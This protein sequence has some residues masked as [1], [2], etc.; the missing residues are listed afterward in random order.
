MSFHF[1]FEGSDTRD[2]LTE[3][4]E[5]EQL[6]QFRVRDF[7]SM[8][9]E[10][11]EVF[12]H[13]DPELRHFP[14]VSRVSKDLGCLYAVPPRRHF[15]AL[16]DAEAYKIEA[17]Y[18]SAQF[19]S[20]MSTVARK[21][22]VQQSQGVAVDVLNPRR[23]RLMSFSPYEV[24][25]ES[26]DPLETDIRYVSRVTLRVPLKVT[27]EGYTR[28]VFFGRRIYTQTEAYTEV[29]K[30]GGEVERVPVYGNSIEHGFGRIPLVLV[31]L[32]EA[33]KGWFLPRVP[34][35]LLAMQIGLNLAL[36]DTLYIASYQCFASQALIGPGA[37]QAIKQAKVS[38]PNRIAAYDSDEGLQHVVINPN[39][40]LDKYLAVIDKSLRIWSAN[41]YVSPES[42]LN[43]TG[44]TGDAKAQ[45]RLDQEE[46]R[47]RLESVFA[48]AE[49]DIAELVAESLSRSASIVP[50]PAPNVKI[51]YHY[52]QPRG[53]NSLQEAQAK[54]V[55]F[56]TGMDSLREYVARVAGLFLDEADALIVERLEQ[57]KDMF[58][59]MKDEAPVPGLD[60][61]QQ[62]AE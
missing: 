17:V 11:A 43:S 36:S 54:A 9:T 27:E 6:E 40:P 8:A 61:I 42:L 19:D 25:V 46:E 45:E 21:S 22:V 47:R 57:A 48:D 56:R 23:V 18:K 50:V 52:V 7:S 10:L 44:I 5:S 62:G 16:S 38:G 35:D 28:A 59:G 51:D 3:R 31:R 60:R 58:E 53:R 34:G 37:K 24:V 14:L 41:A 26:D 12:G 13:S 30:T 55:E 15:E 4:A 1:V 29:P 20:F 32:E 33:P 39:P 2:M 49:Q